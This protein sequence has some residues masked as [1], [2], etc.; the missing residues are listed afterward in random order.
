MRARESCSRALN[1]RYN[2]RRK[3]SL[4]STKE[5]ISKPPRSP[6]IYGALFA[7][8]ATCLQL[9]ARIVSQL[10]Q[11]YYEIRLHEQMERRRAHYRETMRRSLR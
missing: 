6:M 1:R 10:S 2:D 5:S 3:A 8:V 7:L 11:L 9:I 4:P